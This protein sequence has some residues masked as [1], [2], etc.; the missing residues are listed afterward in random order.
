MFIKIIHNP[1]EEC[2]YEADSY[3]YRQLDT[4]LGMTLTIYEGDGNQLQIDTDDETIIYIM[5]ND[6]RTIDSYNT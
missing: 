6:G 5:N 3:S 4:K 2:M 1:K